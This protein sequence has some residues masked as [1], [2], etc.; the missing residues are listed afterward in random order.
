M[1]DDLEDFSREYLDEVSPLSGNL[2]V[3]RERAP[4]DDCVLQAMI[5]HSISKRIVRDIKNDTPVAK[6]PNKTQM[7]LLARELPQ[8]MTFEDQCRANGM[9]IL[10]GLKY[11]SNVVKD[12]NAH[13]LRKGFWEGFKFKRIRSMQERKSKSEDRRTSRTYANS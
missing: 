7:T 9:T 5:D 3:Q 1:K 4:L 10:E 13:S 8:Q 11:L 6:P 2:T 12:E